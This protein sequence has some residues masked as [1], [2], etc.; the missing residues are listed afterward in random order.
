[1]SQSDTITYTCPV[2]GYQNTWTRDQIVQRGT[3]QVFRGPD[4]KDR[5][6]L[7]CKNPAVPACSGRYVVT[8]EREPR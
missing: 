6:S 7:A 1:M 5:Y 8:V 2:C 3:K 4:D